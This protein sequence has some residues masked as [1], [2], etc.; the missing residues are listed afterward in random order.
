L[1]IGAI[2][3]SVAIFAAAAPFGIFLAGRILGFTL[4]DSVLNLFFFGLIA[5]TLLIGTSRWKWVVNLSGLQFLGEISY[6]VYLVHMLVFDVVDKASSRF[7]PQLSAMPGKF[8]LMVL[9]FL[10]AAICTLA[11]A[12][13]SRWYF[14]EPFLR[15]KERLVEKPNAS[16]QLS[17]SVPADVIQLR[18]C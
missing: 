5:S 11:V 17:T 13:F 1:A 10:M 18:E 7:A 12:Y 16:K 9:R 8:W 3:A 6:G 15:L 2:A 4:R 14:E